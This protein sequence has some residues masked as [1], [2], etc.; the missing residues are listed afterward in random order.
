MD[1]NGMVE[2]MK[3]HPEYPKMGMIAS[4]LGVVR[5]TSLDGRGVRGIEVSFDGDMVDKILR[6]IKR[7]PGIVEVMV[8]TYGGRRQVGDEIMKVV[9]GGDVRDNVFPALI[10]AVDRIKSEASMKNELF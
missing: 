10:R 8:E 7:M 1:L 3:A 2:K 9:V 4:H 6:E 5:G